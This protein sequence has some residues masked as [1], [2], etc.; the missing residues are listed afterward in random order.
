M[1]SFDYRTITDRNFVDGDKK[2]KESY[3]NSLIIADEELNAKNIAF[4][5]LS[6]GVFNG[7]TGRER[8]LKE[9]LEIGIQAIKE[10]VTNNKSELK[11]IFMV[12]CGVNNKN[13]DEKEMLREA[14]RKFKGSTLYTFSDSSSISGSK[15]SSSS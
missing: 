7:T 5:L 14:L 8:G 11:N 4:S 13:E 12:S 3:T 2:L 6:S 10:W 15:S 9:V 1:N